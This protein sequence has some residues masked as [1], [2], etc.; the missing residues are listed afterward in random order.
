MKQRCVFTRSSQWD[1]G[2]QYCNLTI[3][4]V[5]EDEPCRCQSQV[6]FHKILKVSPITH[7]L[8]IFRSCNSFLL[9]FSSP[10]LLASNIWNMRLL[11]LSAFLLFWESQILSTSAQVTPITDFPDYVSARA[12]VQNAASSGIYDEGVFNLG[13][14]QQQS[15]TCLCGSIGAVSAQISEWVYS[16]ASYHCGDTIEASS[17]AGIFHEYCTA[18]TGPPAAAT[19]IASTSIIIENSPTTAGISCNFLLRY[20]SH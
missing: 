5:V 17:A 1:W 3:P 9:F 16:Y 10:Q 12:C 4:P 6:V 11:I 13:C 18:S 15:Q 7:T 19:T 8:L 14:V 20:Y 2:W